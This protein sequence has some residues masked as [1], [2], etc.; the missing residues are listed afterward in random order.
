M[1][2]KR[3]RCRKTSCARTA[4]ATRTVPE[5]TR[6]HRRDDGDDGGAVA[7]DCGGV[8]RAMNRGRGRQVPVCMGRPA[9]GR[10]ESRRV[11]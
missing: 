4:V 3:H 2:R 8:R 5:A 11:P 9:A 1:T 6:S 10:C 7:G